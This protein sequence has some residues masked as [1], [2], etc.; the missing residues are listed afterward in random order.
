LDKVKFKDV[1]GADGKT[2]IDTKEIKNWMQ[3]Q[4][5]VMLT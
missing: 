1:D 3:Q 2:D 5:Q 4:A